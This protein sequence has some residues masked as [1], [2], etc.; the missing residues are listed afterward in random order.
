MPLPMFGQKQ[1]PAVKKITYTLAIA[2][3]KGGVGKSTVA[4]NLARALRLMGFNVGIMDADVYGPSIRK[5]LPEDKMPVQ[6]GEMLTPALCSGISMISM[7]YFQQGNAAAA[8]RA[9]IANGIVSQFINNV[10]WGALD[11][12]LIDFPPG[13]GDIQ[14]TLAQKGN[15]IGAVMV[16]TP[17][18]IAIIDVRKAI[19]MFDLVRV[20]IIGVIEN[21]SGY[22]HKGSDEMLYLFGKGGG[23]K[24]AVECGAPFLGR[25]PIDPELSLRGDQGLS[26]FAGKKD[27]HCPSADP[28]FE[29]AKKIHEYTQS[30]E[31]NQADCMIKKIIQK[32][33]ATFTIEWSD[34]V[35]LDYSL[36][37]LQKRCPCAKC[38]DASTGKRMIDETSID[39]N[40][41]AKKI[42]NVGRYAL[43]IEFTTGCSSGIY[44]FDMLRN[45]L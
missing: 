1:A 12:L 33:K 36:S 4:V 32:D 21:M 10:E 20:P 22:Y 6:K 18:E 2:A 43:R 30:L 28:F 25:I 17:Q 42:M 37:D 14:L 7:A 13:T 16:T 38:M 34:G 39:L 27:S 9:P 15:L 19:H 11:Y 44:G 24:L 35:I 3:G 29:I 40:V 8:V 31:A 26:I 41:Q 45:D 23:E 5:M